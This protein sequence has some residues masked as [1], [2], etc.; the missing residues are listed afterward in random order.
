MSIKTILVLSMIVIAVNAD[1]VF[2]NEDPK[3]TCPKY[4]CKSANSEASKTCVLGK[5][6]LTDGRTV[7]VNPCAKDEVC[8]AGAAFPNLPTD[9]D[10]DVKCTTPTTPPVVE[11]F[12]YPGETCDEAKKDCRAIAYWTDTK[13]ENKEGTCVSKKCVGSAVDKKCDTLDACDLSLYCK[14]WKA[15][16]GETPAVQGTCALLLK[17]DAVGCVRSTECEAGLI[18]LNFAK[19]GVPAGEN[20]CVDVFSLENGKEV[21]FGDATE[22]TSKA[23]ACKSGVISPDGKCAEYKYDTEAAKIVKGKVTCTPGEKCKYNYLV[24]EAKTADTKD[25][26]C[27][28]DAAGS[29]FCP[30][31]SH[32]AVV[33]DRHNSILGFRKEIFSRKDVHP[34]TRFTVSSTDATKSPTC[35][36]IYADTKYSG[37]VD[38]LKTIT[39][40]DKCTAL[41]LSGNFINLSIFAIVA[42]LA[43]FF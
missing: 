12:A 33:V 24:G 14:G 17:K 43:M 23:N 10:V 2:L 8:P 42:L 37:C 22:A 11:H 35:L 39:G 13:Q 21:K 40:A 36:G 4:S 1:I 7:V 32:D 9:N 16:E 25:C 15:A 38:C 18:C 41:S 6:K 5:G 31:S 29:G 26:N 30:Y 28:F 3:K 34:V 20:K 19:E 27:S